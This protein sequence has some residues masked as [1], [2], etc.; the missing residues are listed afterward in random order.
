[1]MPRTG[2]GRIYLRGRTYWV[3]YGWRGEDR[4]ESS[5]STK[6]QDATKLLRKRMAEMGTG[7]VT[8]P[9][10]EKVTFEDLAKMIRDDYAVNGR[11]SSKRLG[12]ALKHLRGF[13]GGS[14]ALNISTD[15]LTSYIV[16]R[17]ESGAANSS[18]MK[19]LGALKRA[20]NLAVRAR[21]L[22]NRP[23]IPSVEVDNTREGFFGAEELERLL[24]EL[25]DHVRPVAQF[26]AL[27]GWRKS[28]V[29]NLQWSAVDFGAGVVRIAPG[30]TKNKEGRTFPFA[31][32]PPLE[33]LLERQRERTRALEREKGQIIPHVFHRRGQPLRDINTAWR[34][35]CER[36]GLKGWLFHDLRRTAVMNLERAAVSRSV[37]MKLTG[38]KT[39]SVYRRYAIADAASLSEGVEKLAQ[40]H[41][42]PTEPRKVVPIRQAQG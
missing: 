27:T 29:L 3:Q 35:A 15:Q 40:L 33:A 24:H 32:L 41:A 6:R 21:R 30:T 31:A 12:L 10:E 7:K 39:E 25:P 28:E 17:Q 34:S 37:A 38:H 18:I 11:R 19:E 8:G 2:T 9:A 42:G 23:Y 5:G 13:F 36:A 4:R 20:F 22:T 14:A 16:L 26:A 1:M